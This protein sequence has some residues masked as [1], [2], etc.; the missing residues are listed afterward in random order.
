M[1]NIW[2]LQPCNFRGFSEYPSKTAVFY[3]K[4]IQVLAIH[5]FPP[6]N[7]MTWTGLAGLYVSAQVEV[8]NFPSDPPTKQRSDGAVKVEF[9]LTLSSKPPW[10]VGSPFSPAWWLRMAAASVRWRRWAHGARGIIQTVCWAKIGMFVMICL[11]IVWDISAKW[12]PWI[13]WCFI[14]WWSFF[15]FLSMGLWHG[16]W[17][18]SHE[19]SHLHPVLCQVVTM[20]EDLKA[21]VVAEGTT[22]EANYKKFLGGKWG[23]PKRGKSWRYNEVV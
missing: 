17:L 9:D 15:R 18:L 6:T 5:F 23:H 14:F 2:W 11:T 19:I 4:H 13:W 8:E 10:H 3:Q 21:E 7:P 12:S 22:E 16:W 20:L 1:K